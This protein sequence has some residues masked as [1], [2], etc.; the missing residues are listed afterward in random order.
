MHV[1]NS[2]IHLFSLFNSIQLTIFE[3]KVT[4]RYT[5]KVKLLHLITKRHNKWTL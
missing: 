5:L 1:L 4:A 3:V 2:Q